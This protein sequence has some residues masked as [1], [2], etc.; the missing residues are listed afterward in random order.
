MQI[1]IIDTII[2]ILS[3]VF[4]ARFGFGLREFLMFLRS[5]KRFIFIIFVRQLLSP[6]RVCYMAVPKIKGL[7]LSCWSF[8]DRAPI[9][10]LFSVQVPMALPDT[11]K[12]VV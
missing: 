3:L 11:K 2:R 6:T 8:N 7:F 5:F 9:R 1:K 10:G 4:L 12:N